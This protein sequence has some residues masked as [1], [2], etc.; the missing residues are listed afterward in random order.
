MNKFRKYVSTDT[1]KYAIHREKEIKV[2]EK[3]LEFVPIEKKISEP[4]LREGFAEFC[5]SIRV[6]WHLPNES[7]ES[8]S[9][10]SVFPPNS[11]WKR[12][13]FRLNLEVLLMQT[14]NELLK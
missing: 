2:L 13:E 5:W 11:K 14:E 10:K 4:E 6:K 3:A 1:Y 9:K 8:F 12:T 7:S